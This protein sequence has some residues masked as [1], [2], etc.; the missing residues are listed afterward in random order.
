[1]LGMDSQ[2]HVPHR[3]DDRDFDLF[4]SYIL[5]ASVSCRV[6]VEEIDALIARGVNSEQLEELRKVRKSIAGYALI[7]KYYKE[8]VER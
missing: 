8:G 6:M 2:T 4:T 5:L 3:S 7:N 1:M